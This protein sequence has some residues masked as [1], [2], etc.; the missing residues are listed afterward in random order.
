LGSDLIV[1]DYAKRTRV[2][3]APRA[4]AILHL[5]DRWRPASALVAHFP[6]DSANALTHALAELLRAGLIER[7]RSA[8][9]RPCDELASWAP[10]SPAATAT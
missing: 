4:L 9:D 10:W 2:T 7:S 3:A 1:E 8:R 5:F 6:N